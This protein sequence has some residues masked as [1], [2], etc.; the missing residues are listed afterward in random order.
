MEAATDDA[1]LTTA[2]VPALDAGADAIAMIIDIGTS[3]E[4]AG[5]IAP[6]TLLTS[7]AGEFA[8]VPILENDV[9]VACVVIRTVEDEP[10]PHVTPIPAAS[11]PPVTPALS[12]PADEIDDETELGELVEPDDEERFAAPSRASQ[13]DLTR[14]HAPVSLALHEFQP[15][16]DG[17]GAAGPAR[18]LTLLNDVNMQV[19]AELGRRRLKVRDIVALQPGSVVEL[20]RAAGSPVDVLVNGE[21]VWHGE[22]VIVDEEFGIRVSEIVVDEN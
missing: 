11:A 13:A 6:D 4:H 18:P 12:A 16:A 14:E 22:V 8:A 15:L 2:A 10:A 5:E 17:P 20:D 19:T 21:L 9:R 3:V 1:Q 7:V